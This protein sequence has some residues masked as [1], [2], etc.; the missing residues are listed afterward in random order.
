MDQAERIYLPACWA[1]LLS[2]ILFI[3]VS[4]N[5]FGYVII[6]RDLIWFALCVAMKT[7]DVIFALCVMIDDYGGDQSLLLPTCYYVW[8]KQIFCLPI[9]SIS[10]HFPNDKYK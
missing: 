3:S 10:Y 6:P 9:I 2:V 5:I 8:W 4:K 7:H 1:R